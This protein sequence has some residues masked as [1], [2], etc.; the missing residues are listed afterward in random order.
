MAN[1]ELHDK[2]LHMTHKDRK[3]F[4]LKLK[5]NSERYDTFKEWQKSYMKW[6]PDKKIDY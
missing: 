6:F 5:N 1:V 4:E 3:Q 2:L